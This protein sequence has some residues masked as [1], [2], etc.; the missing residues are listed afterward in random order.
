MTPL[1]LCLISILFSLCAI[2]AW[3][4]SGPDLRTSLARTNE[5]QTL[6]LTSPVQFYARNGTTAIMG[7]GVTGLKVKQTMNLPAGA[8]IISRRLTI[9]YYGGTD[10]I[11]DNVDSVE[12]D[13]V[14]Q[15]LYGPLP[16]YVSGDCTYTYN[17]GQFDSHDEISLM[18]AS[19][20][21]SVAGA[22]GTIASQGFVI[23]VSGQSDQCV[24]H[25]RF[26]FYTFQEVWNE[27]EGK[28]DVKPVGGLT[29]KANFVWAEDVKSQGTT[30]GTGHATLKFTG[31][32][33]GVTVTQTVQYA[34]PALYL[35]ANAGPGYV[36]RMRAFPSLAGF[37]GTVNVK[38][39]DADGSPL[40][41]SVTAYGGMPPASYSGSTDAQSNAKIELGSPGSGSQAL[42]LKVP[43]KIV[44][45]DI[46][47]EQSDT[48]PITQIVDN[49]AGLVEKWPVQLS[50]YITIHPDAM[51]YGPGASRQSTN[52]VAIQVLDRTGAVIGS[53]KNFTI[54]HPSYLNAGRLTRG[55]GRLYY[56]VNA[57]PQVA[58]YSMK[59]VYNSPEGDV[60]AGKSGSSPTVMIQRAA[61]RPFHIQFVL[62]RVGAWKNLGK[63]YDAKGLMPTATIQGYC[64]YI[65]H[66]MPTDVTYSY[67]YDYTP[68]IDPDDMW[69]HFNGWHLNRLVRFLDQYRAS[70]KQGIDKVVGIVP[71]GYLYTYQAE[72]STSI[73]GHGGSAG[74]AFDNIP[75][76][77][78]L[79]PTLTVKHHALHEILHT[80]GLP[81][82]TDSTVPSSNGYDPVLREPMINVP[83]SAFSAVTQPVMNDSAGWPYPNAQE[84]S[85]MLSMSTYDAVSADMA[86]APKPQAAATTVMHIGCSVDGRLNVYDG[87]DTTLDPVFSEEGAVSYP[88]DNFPY[89]PYIVEVLDGSSN[90]LEKAYFW[91]PE[92]APVKKGQLTLPGSALAPE[93]LLLFHVAFPYHADAKKIYV[94]TTSMSGNLSSLYA[95]RAASANPPTASALTMTSGSLA[96]QLKFSWHAADVDNDPLFFK[97]QFSRDSGVTWEN[98]ATPHFANNLPGDFAWEVEKKDFSAGGGYS[99]RVLCS[100]GFYTGKAVAAGPFTIGGRDDNPRFRLDRSPLTLI[101]KEPCSA[102]V[103]LPINNDGYAPLKVTPNWSAMPG[104]IKPDAQQSTLEVPPLGQAILTL[105]INLPTS[106]SFSCTLPL[107]T[108]D[109]K[110][111]T[112]SL[113]ITV[114]VD[115]KNHAPIASMLVFSEPGTKDYPW[116]PGRKI[117]IYAAE[118]NGMKGLTAAVKLR[119]LN[120]TGNTVTIPLSENGGTSGTYGVV[121]TVP[122]SLK[123]GAYGAMLAFTDPVTKLSDSDGVKNAGTDQVVYIGQPNLTPVFAR[124]DSGTTVVLT[125]GDE[126]V[127]NYSVSDANGNPVSVYVGFPYPVR[128]DPV[129]REIRWRAN[130]LM[131]RQSLSI[132]GQ[133]DKLGQT[134]FQYRITVNKPPNYPSAPRRAFFV[135]LYDNDTLVGSAARTVT[136][137]CYE[138]FQ[139]GVQLQMRLL[140]VTA[141]TN[142]SSV[143]AYKYD[144]TAKDYRATFNLNPASLTAGAV[145]EFRA[146]NYDERNTADVSAPP[147]RVNRPGATTGA[148]AASISA[149]AFAVGGSPVV[150]KVTVSNKTGQPWSGSEGWSIATPDGKADPLTGL[151]AVVM[152]PFDQVATDASYTFNIAATATVKTGKLTTAW[153]LKHPTLGYLGNTVSASVTV[154]DPVAAGVAPG[155]L[156]DYLLGKGA[157]F[158]GMDVN[159]DGKVDIADIVAA[160]KVLQVQY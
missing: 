147:I 21:Y 84:Y 122:T 43:P 138:P 96:D 120:I 51:T 6:T 19:I 67:N 93:N 104:W 9:H 69:T 145:Y 37:N 73:I 129:K 34:Y 81:D 50:P 110:K 153:R 76:A 82:Q 66:F 132:A 141:W 5:P 77:V 154:I 22:Q 33:S 28:F 23:D 89:M 70:S 151:T 47:G 71:P 91:G 42:A 46:P 1:R 57:T 85:H 112:A 86:S 158:N 149:P 72:F 32:D 95:Q 99:F 136:V 150:V 12:F 58:Q 160:I 59:A 8:T 92:P 88:T 109:P 78:L 111:S 133:D 29:V 13:F 143:V 87:I 159:Q 36:A 55:F 62:C 83:N 60:E 119:P 127:L 90:V 105:N 126:L 80:T 56:P 98:F 18:E 24:F 17:G 121:W 75:G 101:A 54:Y 45:G 31:E 134:A 124:H 103:T 123:A 108:N 74:L 64:D 155:T 61:R 100:D 157:Q 130:Q 49:P 20:E 4:Q 102:G 156:T 137:E 146:L 44:F 30:D 148:G 63:L 79:D 14:R 26:S 94:G 35:M 41:G 27:D 10:T 115:R 128:L 97:L 48:L 38:L 11:V 116:Q 106:G 139:T 68:P 118:L 117:N 144:S 39:T 114:T 131:K 53:P 107:A 25:N 3:T 65:C 152:G 140:G 113:P 7:I 2:P 40:Q 125:Q 16:L 15:G 142:L 135:D 52:A